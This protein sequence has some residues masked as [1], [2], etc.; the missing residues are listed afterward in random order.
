MTLTSAQE[1]ETTPRAPGGTRRETSSGHAGAT[2]SKPSRLRTA[3][4]RSHLHRL[5]H[6]LT[7]GAPGL[8]VYLATVLVPM[9]IVIG[10][11]TTDRNTYRPIT[12]FIGFANYTQL[13]HDPDFRRVLGNTL[14]LTLIITIVP[15]VLGLA[16]AMLLDRRGWVFNAMRTVFFVPVV[17]S[18]VVVSVIWASILTDDGLLNSL[19]RG[20]G[21]DHP[22]GWLSDPGL[23]LYSVASIMCWQSLGFCVVIY[24]AGLQGVPQELYEAASIDGAGAFMRF[25]KVTWPM[26]APSVTITTVLTLI[27]GFKVF[28]QIQVIT[29]GG[30]GTGTTETLAFDIV[31]TGVNGIHIGYSAAMA[32]VMLVMVAVL[33]TVVLRLLQRRE[34]S[35]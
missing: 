15:N 8:L 26:L 1:S 24:L 3:R 10:T 27:S 35:Q 32:T 19:L 28:D 33:S 34:V 21:M 11:S 16:V 25:R 4:T 29:N 14:I 30:P 13:A 2:V 5:L 12:R 22:P 7:F 6:L 31:Q 9:A 20:L 17:L 18:S 23:A